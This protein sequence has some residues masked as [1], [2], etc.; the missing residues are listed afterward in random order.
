MGAIVASLV[1][2]GKDIDVTMIGVLIL[3]GSLIFVGVKLA[4]TFVSYSRG[5]A[6]DKYFLDI[7]QEM[8]YVDW[9]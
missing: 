3:I 2:R 5:Y 6:K 9:K 4:N 1:Y 8:E 7:L